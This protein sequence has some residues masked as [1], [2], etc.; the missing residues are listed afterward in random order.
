LT[1]GSWNSVITSSIDRT[2]KVWNMNY[3]F[4]QAT[5]SATLQC[6]KSN[7]SKFKISKV[8][9]SEVKMSK[10]KMSKVKMSKVKMSKNN[11]KCRIRHT[12]PDRLAGVW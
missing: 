1:V 5:I 6:R 10:V 2:V 12:T 9:T 8:K 4:E 7:M 11:K 3:I